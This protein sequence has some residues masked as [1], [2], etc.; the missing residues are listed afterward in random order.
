MLATATPPPEGD[1]SEQKMDPSNSALRQVPKKAVSAKV[2]ITS[3]TAPSLNNSE[4]VVGTTSR[5]N[6]QSL[7]RT[8]KIHTGPP[9]T[10]SGGVVTL[11]PNSVGYK[12]YPAAMLPPKKLNM[13]WRTWC[14]K[15]AG[16]GPLNNSEGV[17][18]TTSQ[19]NAQSLAMTEKVHSDPLDFK[20][21]RC[22]PNS[23][24]YKQ[25]PAAKLP[26]PKKKALAEPGTEREPASGRSTT[27]KVSLEPPHGR[28]HKALQ[29][30]RKY[31]Q[32][33]L[34]FQW[35]RCDPNP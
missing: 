20:G 11:T 22:D 5:K 27:R 13:R 4:G 7:A 6:T 9:S 30:L 31:I 18:G 2:M 34:D 21:G 26:P 29:G 1:A 33:P 28:I 16:S 15:G 8:E 25:Y 3:S 12:Q 24:G 35:W 14:R 23:V 17:V 32:A 10:F 19:K